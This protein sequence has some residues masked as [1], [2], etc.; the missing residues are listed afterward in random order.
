MRYYFDLVTV[1]WHSPRFLMNDG[2]VADYRL[3]GE[4]TYTEVSVSFDDG[5]FFV[6]AALLLCARRVGFR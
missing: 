4:S 5:G 1:R 3:L 6:A 2:S